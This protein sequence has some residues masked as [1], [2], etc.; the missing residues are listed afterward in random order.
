M[1]GVNGI[2]M[3]G[4]LHG[5]K[6]HGSGA[7][8]FDDPEFEAEVR[9]AKENGLELPKMPAPATKLAKHN[10]RALSARNRSKSTSDVKAP[11][12]PKVKSAKAERK[13]RNRAVSGCWS[14][15]NGDRQDYEMDEFQDDYTEDFD[16]TVIDSD[17]D[18]F[19]DVIYKYDS[20]KVAGSLDEYFCNMNCD[21]AITELLPH[22][23]NKDT[24]LR[25]TRE[26]ISKSL[27]LDYS[28]VAL[29]YRL[30][31]ELLKNK[32]INQQ[33][34][35]T[36]FDELLTDLENL[37]KDT[38][39][40]RE[41]LTLFIAK[42][43]NDKVVPR[44]VFDD[45]SSKLNDNRLAL[46]CALEVYC[47]LNNPA[48]FKG[49][50]E[51]CGGSDPLDELDIKMEWILKEFLLSGDFEEVGKR[52]DELHAQHY[53]HEFVYLAGYYSINHMN[54]NIMNQLAGLLKYLIDNG[55]LLRSSLKPGFDHLFK[56]LAELYIDLPPA[57]SLCELFIKKCQ[58]FLDDSIIGAFPKPSG[59]R[60]RTL[61]SG[62]DKG[63][64]YVIDSQ[65]AIVNGV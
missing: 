17:G 4:N 26:L 23:Y 8:Q 52:L 33:T 2:E 62:D 27:E 18:D 64:I 42:T 50:F 53:N 11:S 19:E 22:V 31:L 43:V 13:A 14:K 12:P 56:S 41:N 60:A 28:R 30:I 25:V 65:Q 20:S 15:K 55:F 9:Y 24:A 51:A 1:N 6:K 63:K 46:S 61:S 39:K 5:K 49:K 35:V 32:H 40:A 34:V 21:E 29:G 57:Y 54:E 7:K 59:K 45:I 47:Y 38:P 16:D 44:L 58:G 48:L 37:I 3:N 36:A 10:P